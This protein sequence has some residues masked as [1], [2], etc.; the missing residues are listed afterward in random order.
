MLERNE[1]YWEEGL[2]KLD[3]VEWHVVVD[4][5][6]RILKIQAGELDAAI[7]I[8]FNRVAELDADPEHRRPPR[9]VHPRGPSAAQPRAPNGLVNKNVR[10]ALNMAID[11]KSIVDVVTFGYGKPGQFIHPC[12]RAVLQPRQPELSVRPGAGQG[13]AR[14]RRCGG[15]ELLLTSS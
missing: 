15:H 7:F 5:N 13:D 3:G 2:P 11:V 6:T 8:P 14:D 9:S 1:H 12:W 4:D 10:K